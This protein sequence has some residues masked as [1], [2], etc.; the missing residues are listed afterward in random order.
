MARN[1][2]RRFQHGGGDLLAEGFG[3]AAGRGGD[4]QGGDLAQV[5]EDRGAQAVGAFFVFPLAQAEA[6]LA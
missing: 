6:A 2:H 3:Q 5:V 4:A 1:S